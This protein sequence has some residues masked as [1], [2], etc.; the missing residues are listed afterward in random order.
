MKPHFQRSAMALLLAASLTAAIAAPPD[1]GVTSLQTSLAGKIIGVD[2][3]PV[4]LARPAVNSQAT[5]AAM[6]AGPLSANAAVRIA[7]LNNPDLQASLGAESTS[8]TDMSSSNA[9]AKLRATQAITVLSA[10]TYKAWTQAVASA[11]TVALLR[12]ARDTAQ[13]RNALARRMVQVGNLSK[14]TQAQYQAA[15]SD[16]GIALVRAEQAA[17]A[18]REQLT[19][20]LGLWGEQAS[21][22]LPSTLPALPKSAQELPHAE[23]LALQAR[24]DLAATRMQWEIKQRTTNRSS[25]DDLWDGMGDAAKVR[26]QAIILRSQARAAYFNYRSAFDIAQHMQTEVLPTRKFINDE[27]LLRYNGMLTSVF[28]V[29]ADSQTQTQTMQATVSAQR[30]FWLAHADLQAVLAGAPLDAL[31]SN[32]GGTDGSGAPAGPSTAAH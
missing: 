25:I 3:Q 28:D 17:F 32:P 11:Q 23:S 30:D 21:Y 19:Q 12:E 10:R 4:E 24:T 31:G 29:L 13:T 27:L 14:L 16:S 1:G 15:Q 2:A 26:A 7:L 22:A 6:L 18:S 20:L 5:V 9:P 8:I